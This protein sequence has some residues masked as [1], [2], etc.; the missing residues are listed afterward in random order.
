MQEIR[1]SA[2]NYR[3]VLTVIFDALWKLS[4]PTSNVINFYNL[5]TTKGTHYEITNQTDVYLVQRLYQENLL[6]E[7]GLVENLWPIQPE[8]LDLVLSLLQDKYTVYII[9]LAPEVKHMQKLS[10]DTYISEENLAFSFEPGKS[11][12]PKYIIAY[13]NLVLCHKILGTK[14]KP[15]LFTSNLVSELEATFRNFKKT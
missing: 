11:L 2:S 8:P 1:L 15:K 3:K 12:L 10:I 6:K 14:G 5:L 4:E 9:C 13:K 7:A